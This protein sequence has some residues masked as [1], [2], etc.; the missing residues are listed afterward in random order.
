MRDAKG[1]TKAPDTTLWRE[2]LHAATVVRTTGLG[3]RWP[4]DLG[5]GIEADGGP[6]GTPRALED[7]RH[8]RR[9]AG[10]ALQARGRDRRGGRRARASPPTRPA[11]WPP[12][13]PGSTSATRTPS[14]P[15][16]RCGGPSSRR[17][18]S[19]P[20][21]W[22]TTSNGPGSTTADTGTWSHAHQQAALRVG[23][24][25]ARATRGRSLSARCSARR[26]VIVA[27]GPALFGRDP[28]E[29]AKVADRVL[30]DPDAIAL[31]R[32]APGH[33]AGLCHRLGAGHRDRHRRG[34][35]P[36]GCSA[37]TRPSCTPAVAEAAVDSTKRALGAPLTDGPAGGGAIASPPRGARSSSSRGWPGRAR[38]RSWPWS[39]GLRG[40]RVRGARAPR[41]RARRRAP[42]P[43]RPGI[44]DVPDHRLVS[45]APRRT[46]G[47]RSS[48]RHVLVLDEAGMAADRDIAF[49]LDEARL[50]GSKVVHGGRRP[51]ARGRRGRR[52]HGRAGRTPRRGRPHPGSERP[53]ARTSAEREALAELRAGD[54]RAGRRVLR[55]ERPGGHRPLRGREALDEL[56][57]R[58]PA[59]V[60]AG[61]DTAMF[62]WRRANVAELNRLAREQM[63]G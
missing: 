31:R 15:W 9:G 42:W 8:P 4:S 23:R 36:V 44:D 14:T 49:L 53:P 1:G 41:P 45:L 38:P 26:D 32:C 63:V 47:W 16:S 61:K 62:A 13:T 55:L 27:V 48:D 7:R 50:A 18:A 34:T 59:D 43:A 35:W 52:G 54:V 58:W 12:G 19:H 21:S 25:R 6:T 33:R 5:Y 46:S 30:R 60:A 40:R 24:L 37:P 20:A 10:R 2:H 51:S 56:I 28:G 29:L 39:A 22:T 17:P 3:R 11:R 57:E